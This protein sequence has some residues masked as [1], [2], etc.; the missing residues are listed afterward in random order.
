[1]ATYHGHVD[2]SE[3]RTLPVSPHGGYLARGGGR[4]RGTWLG[5]GAGVGL[6]IGL[7]LGWPTQWA[8]G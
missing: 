3:V 8:A 6:G 2:R 5:V 4:G 7:V 1:M